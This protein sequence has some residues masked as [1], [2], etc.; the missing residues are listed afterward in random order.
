MSQK[1]RMFGAKKEGCCP[2]CG[3][4]VGQPHKGGC[5]IERCP[6]CGHQRLT[7]GCITDLPDL[8]WTGDFPGRT[9]AAEL[10]L[11][12]KWVGVGNGGWE[13]CSAADDD[14][15]PDLNRLYM[16]CKWNKE[17]RKWEKQ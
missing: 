3:A 4:E 7:C 2:D 5:D 6:E 9:E 17:T 16:E 1:R 8:P 14:A 12:C 13:V 15:L 10:G 11:W